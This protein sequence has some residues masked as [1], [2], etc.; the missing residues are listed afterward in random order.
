MSLEGLADS[1]R[2]KREPPTVDEIR[3]LIEVVERS[4]KD[5]SVEAISEDLRF[6]AAYNALLTS[7]K[8]AL[9][10]DGYRTTNQAG[11]HILTFE[12]LHSTIGADDSEIRKLKAF[13]NQRG[14]AT[15][16]AAGAISSGQL[17]GAIRSAQEL[18]QRVIAWLHEHHPNLMIETN[19]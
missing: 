7:S 19:S 11:H 18:H 5:A 10:A 6:I 4:L 15:Y 16:D 14:T 1:N 3:G 8:I 12:T 17:R 2:L 13:A 9:R